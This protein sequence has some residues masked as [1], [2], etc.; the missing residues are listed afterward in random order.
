MTQ[1]KVFF[2]IDVGSISTKGVIIDKDNQILARLMD[3]GKLLYA[4]IREK[5]WERDWL[6]LGID[7]YMTED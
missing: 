3:A 7:I 2:G 4:V 6:Q 5:R 1:K